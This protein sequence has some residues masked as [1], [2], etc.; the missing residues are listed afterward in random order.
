MLRLFAPL[1]FLLIIYGF[2]YERINDAILDSVFADLVVMD[3]V[4]DFRSA[5][6]FIDETLLKM[7]PSQRRDFLKQASENSNIKYLLM[8]TQQM[9][10]SE[11]AKEALSQGG[12]WMIDR[13]P[14]VIFKGLANTPH[15]VRIGPVETLSALEQAQANVQLGVFLIFVFLC[16]VWALLLHRRVNKLNAAARALGEGDLSVRAPEE[17]NLR[18]GELSQTFNQMAEKIQALLSSQKHLANAVSHELRTPITRLKFE[19][20]HLYEL[21]EQQELSESLNSISEDIDELDHLVAELLTY[22]QLEGGM[23][24]LMCET[25]LLHQWL[26]TWLRNFNNP[27]SQITIR[28][29][30]CPNDLKATFEASYLTRALNNLVLNATRYAKNEIVISAEQR[31]NFLCIHVDDDGEGIPEPQRK[32][33]FSPFVRLEKSRARQHGGVGLGLAIVKQIAKWHGG[34]AEVVESPRGGARF[35]LC[36]K[37]NMAD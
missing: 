1:Y 22:A 36:W 21:N 24:E 18:I 29:D 27:Q 30:H 13:Y 2:F 9:D 10:V 5:F 28:L 23:P 7:E 35:S 33:L 6:L 19:M 25:Y 4:S 20:D 3:Y 8:E 14:N 12:V 34:W 32:D 26:T 11:K 31:Q 15:T 37:S 16:L 17:K